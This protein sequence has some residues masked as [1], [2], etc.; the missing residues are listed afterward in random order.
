MNRIPFMVVVEFLP[1]D[2]HSMPALVFVWSVSAYQFWIAPL[3]YKVLMMTSSNHCTRW[4]LTTLLQEQFP[5]LF[6]QRRGCDG[7]NYLQTRVNIISG[8][9]SKQTSVWSELVVPVYGEM[10]KRAR[11]W[12]SN[13]SHMHTHMHMLNMIPMKAA[14]CN[15]GTCIF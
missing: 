10:R 15:F 11:Q 14:I 5:T 12:A 1:E 3:F 2:L 9:R 8:L 6:S 4:G 13:L 7:A